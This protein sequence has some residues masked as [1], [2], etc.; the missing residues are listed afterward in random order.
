MLALTPESVGEFIPSRRRDGCK[1][2]F[3]RVL[4]VAGSRDM[5]GAA[6]LCAR[7][8]LKAGAGLVTVAAPK[9]AQP[10]IA[11]GI[12]EATTCGLSETAAGY[13]APP[14][15]AELDKLIAERGFDLLLIGPG[16]GHCHETAETVRGFLKRCPLSAVIDADAL[17]AIA[18]SPKPESFFGGG[19]PVRIFTPHMGEAARLLKTDNET[20]KIFRDQSALNLADVAGG[21]GVLKDYETAIGSVQ[22]AI[23]PRRTALN[24]GGACELAKGGSGDVLAGLIAGFWA[25]AGKQ[26]G[27]TPET[28]FESACAAVYLHGVCGTLAR[29]ELTEYCVLAGEL[30]A[31]LPAAIRRTLVGEKS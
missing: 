13:L 12:I 6:V 7:A 11:Q 4:I 18:D 16:L 2:D 28:A 15:G 19:G 14:A 9:S 5:T 24:P 31:F 30:L 26:A 25:Q 10:I 22:G 27:F 1:R 17:N 21:V 29:R 3:G 23:A 20:L 8:A